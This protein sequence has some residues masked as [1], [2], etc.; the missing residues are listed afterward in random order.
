MRRTDG[1]PEPLPDGL[2]LPG[3]L[4]FKLG[5]AL[6]AL[7]AVEVVQH[8]GQSPLL[9]GEVLLQLVHHPQLQPG[10][11]GGHLAQSVLQGEVGEELQP[12][13]QPGLAARP[14]AQPGP[15]QR[16]RVTSLRQESLKS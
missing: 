2:V 5:R 14:L 13:R 10:L 15:V 8:G 11:G 1:V 12:A 16:V 6:L 7:L 9:P 4:C 3:M